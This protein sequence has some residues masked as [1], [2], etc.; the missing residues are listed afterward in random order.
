MEEMKELAERIEKM[1][2]KLRKVVAEKN[3][4]FIDP[5]VA[6]VSQEMDVL[7]VAYERMKLAKRVRS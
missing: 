7:I 3:D 4:N 5:E 1:R 2:V 6:K